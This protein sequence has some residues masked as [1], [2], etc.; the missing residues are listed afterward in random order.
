MK[1]LSI[2]II[3][4]LLAFC[5]CQSEKQ[6]NEKQDDSISIDCSEEYL[7]VGLYAGKYRYD[8]IA[9]CVK[10]IKE[11]GLNEFLY[12]TREDIIE[13]LPAVPQ[14][15]IDD[16]EK[17]IANSLYI[18][19]FDGQTMRPE[20]KHGFFLGTPF[21]IFRQTHPQ[22]RG[23]GKISISSGYFLN[24]DLTEA[25][26][27]G[28]YVSFNECDT[29]EILDFLIEDSLQPRLDETRSGEE[30]YYKETLK[31]VMVT[32]DGEER[33]CY[34][35]YNDN[36]DRQF[37]IRYNDILLI[38]I[39]S[40]AYD[41]YY[42]QHFRDLPKEYLVYSQ[43]STTTPRGYEWLSRLSFKTVDPFAV[44]KA[45]PIIRLLHEDDRNSKVLLR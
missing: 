14:D 27:I 5:G 25:E 38:S 22:M 16:F 10:K 4:L 17:D 43:S 35:P 28:V 41:T 45:D 40:D 24:L 18:T 31:R 19:Y 23:S 15:Y 44:L 26:R 36:M 6:K 32:I 8:S 13:K 3:C 20:S 9:A 29:K 7:S 39:M 1:K 37:Y 33:E 42:F 21:D 30:T 11:N 34:V 12:V 2:I